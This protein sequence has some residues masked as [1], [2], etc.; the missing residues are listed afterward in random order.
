M[1]QVQQWS[2][3]VADQVAAAAAVAW[4]GPE[5][6]LPGLAVSCWPDVWSRRNEYHHEALD[7]MVMILK[8]NTYPGK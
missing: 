6:V 2:C 5:V 8:V 3:M 7:R 4:P 1:V